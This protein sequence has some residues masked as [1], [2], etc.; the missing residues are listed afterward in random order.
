MPVSNR[1]AYRTVL[2]FFLII[3][4]VLLLVIRLAAPSLIVPRRT[5]TCTQDSRPYEIKKGDTCWAIAKEYSS[6]VEKL[7][8]VN[9]QMKCELLTQ[10]QKICVPLASQK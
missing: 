4:V 2:P 3:I 8:A 7:Q 5:V 10:G 6:S 9:P 1:G